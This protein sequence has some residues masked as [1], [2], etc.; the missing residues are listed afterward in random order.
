[1]GFED[2]NQL[3]DTTVYPP[4]TAVEQSCIDRERK[5]ILDKTDMLQIFRFLLQDEIPAD[6]KRKE[7]FFISSSKTPSTSFLN[8]KDE[9]T[10]LNLYDY[11]SLLYMMGI[12]RSE[13]TAQDIIETNEIKSHLITSIRRSQGFKTQRTN[14]LSL[15]STIFKHNIHTMTDEGQSSGPGIVGGIKGLF[16]RL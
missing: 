5:D 15:L 10:L 8:D 16:R 6:K 13:K 11:N 9:F 14:L 1:M 2:F 7:L 12:P 3:M 4:D